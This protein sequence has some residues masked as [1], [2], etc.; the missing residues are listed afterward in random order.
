MLSY[1]ASPRQRTDKNQW[2]WAISQTARRFALLLALSVLALSTPA[3]QRT[4]PRQQA[5]AQFDAGVCAQRTGNAALDIIFCTR[6][7]NLGEYSALTLA[8]LYNTRGNAYR[9]TGRI[10]KALADHS[11]AIAA[12]RF[13]A[14]AFVGRALVLADSGKLD[15]ATSDLDQAIALFP[16]FGFAW[17]HRGRIAF[18]QGDDERATSDLDQAL[19]LNASDGEAFAFRALVAFRE[20]RFEATIKDF[21]ASRRWHTGYMYTPLWIYLAGAQ[22]GRRDSTVLDAGLDAPRSDGEWPGILLKSYR[23]D[24]PPQAV[25]Q[26]ARLAPGKYAVKREAEAA[27]YLAQLARMSG[28]AASAAA[29]FQTVCDKALPN[30]VERVMLP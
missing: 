23:G 16:K 6:A 28:D 3:Q 7:L 14:D 9:I 19:V 5:Q 2:P 21:E 22:L 25:V 26:Q 8:T 13:S 4:P 15:A 24:A 17:K 12:N 18:L 29:Y 10:S 20:H 1:L 30:S 27:F 11:A